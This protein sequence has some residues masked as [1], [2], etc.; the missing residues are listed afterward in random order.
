MSPTEDG[1]IVAEIPVSQLTAAARALMLAGRWAQAADLLAAALPAGDAE[2]SDLAVTT[3]EVAVDQDFWIRT[4]V[5]SRAL[6]DATVLASG[7]DLDFL[8]LKH[9]Y[10]TELFRAW[11]PDAAPR[12]P[13]A[14]TELAA[15]ATQLRDAAPSAGQ[16]AWAAFYVGLIADVL[17]GD[18]ETGRT[19]YEQA[20]ADAIESGDE[21]AVS[22]ALRHLGNLDAEA[23]AVEAGRQQLTQSLELRQH[24]GCVPHVLAQL[25]ALAEVS[26]DKAWA[27]TVA[28]LVRTWASGLDGS[29]W[30][31]GATAALLES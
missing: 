31:V 29:P 30:L 13:A 6:E 10:N 7:H 8:R 19:A 28:G 17:S 1:Y 14:V 15:R 20:H 9:D 24:S 22:Y 27:R 12:D 25:L 18:A 5:G 3:A 26:D 23:G 11:E 21:L 4:A 16:R 2:R